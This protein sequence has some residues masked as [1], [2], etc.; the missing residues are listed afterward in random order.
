M[1]TVRLAQQP[2]ATIQ[3]NQA[4]GTVPSQHALSDTPARVALP[5]VIQIDIHFPRASA[6][7]LT[8][9][10]LGRSPEQCVLQPVGP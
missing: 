10:F 2:I 6:D 9:F 3:E 4:R 8:P 5:E 7:T 1:G